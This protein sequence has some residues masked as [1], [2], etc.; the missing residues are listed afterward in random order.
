MTAVIT[1]RP[2][3]PGM[4]R[5][6]RRLAAL[7]EAIDRRHAASPRGRALAALGQTSDAELAAR[8]T[9]RMAEIARILGPRALI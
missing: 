1:I 9:T 8:G 4:F 2:A 3:R 7:I 6:R 5:L